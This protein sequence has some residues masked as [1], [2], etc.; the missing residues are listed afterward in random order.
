MT[1]D[2]RSVSPVVATILMVAIVVI[3]SASIGTVAFGFADNLGGTTI[4]ANNEQ[5]L[6]SLDF[7]PNDIDSFANSATADLDCILWFD[8]TQESFEDGD[9]ISRWADRSGNGF[10]ATSS[11]LSNIEDPK[12]IDDIDGVSAIRFDSADEFEGL[13]T[14]AT[15]NEMGLDGDSQFTASTVV[16]PDNEVDGGVMQIGTDQGTTWGFKPEINAEKQW[17]FLI[18]GE[19]TY[20]VTYDAEEDAE[21]WIVLTHVYDG[22]SMS[23]FK[24]GKPIYERGE[25][26][27]G[28]AVTQTP[29]EEPTLDITN[30]PY[31]IGFFNFDGTDT[32]DDPFDGS[33]A[34]I[35]VLNKAFSDTDREVLE[36]SLDEKHGSAVNVENC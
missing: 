7:D 11:D 32:A 30:D 22:D 13:D 6:Q 34:E 2:D 10:D 1:S 25:A 17:V 23:I 20:V 33:I 16:R 26:V 35:V 18:L 15:A 5:C 4:A 21:E 3:I 31:N 27:G 28:G 8:A 9:Q 29:E 14:D 19:S 12:Y 36:C 24:N